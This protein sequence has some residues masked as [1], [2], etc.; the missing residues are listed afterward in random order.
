MVDSIESKWLL[1]LHHLPPKPDYFRVRIRRRILQLGA[2][3]LKNAAYVLPLSDQARE[4]FEW[5]AQEIRRDGGE[6]I[7]AETKFLSGVT[8]AELAERFRALSDEAYGSVAASARE[9]AG[10][11]RGPGLLAAVARLEQR[12]ESIAQRDHFDAYG[13]SGA[14]GALEEL[15]RQEEAD[16][17]VSR[18][19]DR[20]SGATWVTRQNVFIDRMA[21]AWLIVRFIDRSARFK[22]AA[23]SGYSAAPGELR[24]DMFEGEYGH[25][26]DRCTFE[27]LLDRFGLVDNPG[28]VALAELVHDLDLHDE[29]Y[30]RPEAPGL[31]ALAQGVVARYASDAERVEH[32]RRL[33]D[34]LYAHFTRMAM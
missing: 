24:F 27:T 31:L 13:R 5:L 12:L 18:I 26:G 4:D 16:V 7:V 28:L 17:V 25:E 3:G 21:S 14:L 2:I 33:F 10:G 32:G 19:P 22:F 6:A 29:K 34:Q 20:P 30:G 11:E 8:A 15:R 9:L 1:L 23:A